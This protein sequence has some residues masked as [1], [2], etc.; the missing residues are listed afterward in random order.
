MESNEKEKGVKRK[1]TP[2][3]N[4]EWL[5]MGFVVFLIVAY[6]A[7]QLYGLFNVR[8]KT[9]TAVVSTVYETVQAKALAVR[10]ERLVS[11]DENAVTA[12]SIDDCDKI[13]KGGEI[14]KVFSSSES[15]QEYSNYKSLEQQ[16]KYYDDMENQAVGQA[17]DVESLGKDVINDINGLVRANAAGNFKSSADYCSELN[18]KFTRTQILVGNSIDFS[19]VMKEIEE[20]I[21]AIDENACKPVGYVKAEESGIFSSY[22]DGL[23]TAFDYSSVSSG[24]DAETLQ[25]WIDQSGNVQSTNSL[26]KLITSFEWY[27]CA[28][29]DTQQIKGLENGENIDVSVDGTDHVYTCKILSGAENQLGVEKTAL[30][31]EC[32]EMNSDIASLRTADIELRVNKYE[33]IKMPA[34]AV[35]INNGEKGVYALVASVVE[36]RKAEVLYTQ[37]DYVVLA[38]DEKDEDG[39]RLYDQIITRGKELR[40]GKVYN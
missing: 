27:L 37:G 23:E 30:V 3:L 16:L 19:S 32:S 12:V 25:Q 22:T 28:V 11:A 33:G 15:A 18:D 13:N 24:L 7:V 40:D 31:L 26:G 4:K 2:K 20:K 21:N 8:L 6:L 29:V 9:Q 17:A 14:A 39:I 36:W 34:S 5:A 35:H 1:K 38:Y 10:D